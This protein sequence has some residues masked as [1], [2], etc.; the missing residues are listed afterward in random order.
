LEKR[1]LSTVQADLGP[2]LRTSDIVLVA[3]HTHSATIVSPLQGESDPDPDP[4]YIQMLCNR[5]AATAHQ[6]IDGLEP[7]SLYFASL[8]VPGLTYNRR[9]FLADG[10]VSMAFQPD[11][12]V[13]ERGPVD[14]TLT[15]LVWRNSSGKNLAALA[16][17]ACHGAA[18]CTQF[19][20]GDIPGEIAKR[21]GELLDAPCLYLQGA[22]GDLNPLTTSAGRPAMLDWVD[23]FM[24]HTRHLSLQPLNPLPFRTLS[25]KLPLVYQPLPERSVVLETIHSL[26][27]IAGQDL[28][29]PEVQKTLVLLADLMNIQPGERPDPAKAAFAAQALLEAEQRTLAAIDSRRLLSPCPLRVSLWSMGQIGFAF[30]AAELFALTG[31]RIR[32]AGRGMA[33]LPVTYASPIVGY[34]PDRDSMEKGGYDRFWL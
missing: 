33:L 25:C 27:K 26:G 20:Q 34:L 29:S 19:I 18:I 28:D 13:L 4:D 23:Q 30:V 17:F 24:E 1:L 10:R 5:A 2:S 31:F 14:D 3:T 22:T 7:A 9:A 8:R 11:I 16:H 21:L 12:P 15:I 6:A 32:A